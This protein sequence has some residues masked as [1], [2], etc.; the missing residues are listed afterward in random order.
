MLGDEF[1]VSGGVS[2]EATIRESELVSVVVTLSFPFLLSTSVTSAVLLRR[3][4]ISVG[5]LFPLSAI[6]NLP[7]FSMS[8]EVRCT[9]FSSQFEPSALRFFC[10]F[11]RIRPI[12]TRYVN[13]VL[14]VGY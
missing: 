9:L 13:F 10:K 4:S 5:R 11:V 1:V 7:L 2:E 6:F 8:V 12:R 14:I 3:H